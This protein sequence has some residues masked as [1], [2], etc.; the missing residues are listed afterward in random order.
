MA[1]RVAKLSESLAEL[2]PDDCESI[3]ARSKAEVFC[4]P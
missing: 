4:D 3:G 2:S 1:I